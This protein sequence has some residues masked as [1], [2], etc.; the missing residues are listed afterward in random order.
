MADVISL[1]PDHI[2]NQIAA[3]EVIQ[4]PASV[5]KE[6]LENAIDAGSKHVIVRIKNSGKTLIQVEDDGKGMSETD[7]RLS[8]ERHATSKIKSADDLFQIKTKGF[9]GEAL[10]SIAAIAHVNMKTRRSEDSMGTEIQID[11]SNVVKHE[12]CSHA[13][14]TVFSVKNLFFNVPA[15]RNF[16]K[17]DSIEFKH[18]VDEF[19]RVALTH[20]EVELDLYHNENEIY[21]LA[22]GNIRQRIVAIFGDIINDRLVPV[23]EETSIVK[24][25]GFVGKPENAKK[26][27]GEQFFFVNNR[28]I[29][30]PY[31][32]HAIAKCYED[33]IPTKHHPS[34]FIYM[35]VDPAQLDVNI[36]PTKTEVKFE[37]EKFI[38][39]IIHSTV[40]NSLGRHNM[41]PTL[42]FDSEMSMDTGHFSP[43]K[44]VV[45]PDVKVDSSYNP[46]VSTMPTRN[47]NSIGQTQ[48]HREKNQDWEELFEVARKEKVN[49][50]DTERTIEKFKSP[51]VWSF[52]QVYNSYIVLNTS[53]GLWLV[54]Q[55]IAHESI[56]FEQFYSAMQGEDR[57]SQ[58]LLFP[59]EI[60]LSSREKICLLNE[61]NNLKNLGF[62][63]EEF[64]A[65]RMVVNGVPEAIDGN[66]ISNLLED[67]VRAIDNETGHM[68][69]EIQKN[70]A[71][72]L[73]VNAAVKRGQKLSAEEQESLFTQLFESK[74]PGISPK[75]KPT[76]IKF[77]VSHLENFFK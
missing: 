65:E 46:F 48:N 15:R 57:N 64:S 53:S 11:G 58:Q 1:L 43:D 39:S 69:S 31:L 73:A 44:K 59:E 34:Y 9:R 70:I 10:A 75:G 51:E 61:E 25:F 45:Q 30:S 50:R 63:F 71:L 3:G 6:L 23:E 38:Y 8:F 14:G 27:R 21:R 40:K 62:T 12:A 54:D 26:K 29:R 18:I 49:S 47:E 28:F 66:S 72:S 4:R 24:L 77:D 56:L 74:N 7:A 16:L 76:F 36:H 55:K 41:M 60:Y 5:V 67:I 37:E 19:I 17:S 35:H 42:D 52:F 32:N 13:S 20:P 33:L 22:E 68:P 2:A